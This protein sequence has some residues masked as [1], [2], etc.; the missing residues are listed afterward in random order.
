VVGSAGEAAVALAD[1][2]PDVLLLD[3]DGIDLPAAVA[4]L[5]AAFPDVC[6]VLLS[7]A[8]QPAVLRAAHGGRVCR[9]VL[10][11]SSLEELVEA[12][13]GTAG[14]DLGI[15][16]AGL[17]LLVERVQADG[18]LANGAVPSLTLREREVLALLGAG[19]D[20]RSIARRLGISIHTARGHV[21]RLLGK[22]GA[23]SQ[24][25]AVATARRRGLLS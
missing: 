18:A 6:L 20:P 19:H 17:S 12:L 8:L 22:L 7:R 13:R 5:D 14:D 21:R 2:P 15:G 11:E 4:N 1:Q 3:A 24:L 10:Q 25:E 9:V 23:H 16:P